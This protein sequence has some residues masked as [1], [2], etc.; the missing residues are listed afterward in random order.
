MTYLRLKTTFVCQNIKLKSGRTYGG[1]RNSN[2]FDRNSK[3]NGR[4][5][6]KIEPI[7]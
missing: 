5:T 2:K 6:P 1:T 7:K 3:R 4:K